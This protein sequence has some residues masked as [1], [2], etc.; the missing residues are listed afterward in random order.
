MTDNQDTNIAA[1]K[2]KLAQVNFQFHAPSQAQAQK[3]ALERAH[4]IADE[5]TGLIWKVWIYDHDR[6]EAGGIYLFQDEASAQAYLGGDIFTGLR[7][8][9][10]VEDMQ[11]K[12]FDVNEVNSAITRARLSLTDSN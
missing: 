3:A 12:I 10:G 5:V 1:S 9:P 6:S 11:V 7:N 4:A 2:L 8:M